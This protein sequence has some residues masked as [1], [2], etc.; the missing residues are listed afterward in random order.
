MRKRVFGVVIGIVMALTISVVANIDAGTAY[1]ASPSLI[2]SAK[3]ELLPVATIQTVPTKKVVNVKLTAMSKV[4]KTT[5]M[6]GTATLQVRYIDKSG[7]KSGWKNLKSVTATTT[8]K[9]LSISYKHTIS[10]KTKAEY[11][12]KGVVKATKGNQKQTVTVYSKSLICAG[13]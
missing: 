12:T 2:E 7:K 10:A 8:N 4:A 6:Q 9:T 3:A 5:K 11:R 13:K 1:A